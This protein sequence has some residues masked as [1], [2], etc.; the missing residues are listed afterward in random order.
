MENFI[1][2]AAP[3]IMAIGQF[4]CNLIGKKV[5]LLRNKE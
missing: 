3:S 5:K 4:G 1:T 2:A